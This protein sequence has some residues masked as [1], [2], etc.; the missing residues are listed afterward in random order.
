MDEICLPP[1]IKC[2]TLPVITGAAFVDSINPCAIAVLLILLETL[3]LTGGRNRALKVGLSFIFGL[4][5]AYLIFGIG[6]FSVLSF[7]S[8]APYLHKAIGG[9]AI[10]VGLLNIKDFFF[11]GKGFLME[12]PRSWR[13]TLGSILRKA[14]SP[15]GAFLIGFLVCLFELPCTGGPYIFALGI[16][17]KQTT[18]SLA[19][20]ILLYYNLIFVLP[21]LLITGLVYFGYSTVERATEWKEKNIKLL[22]LIAGI[23]MFGLGI[24]VFLS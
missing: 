12:I 13:P 16:L 14:I 19:L 6:L 5:L 23:I 4:Y 11:Y 21:L 10:L 2:F 22:H 17:A 7:R 1:E 8:L 24:W 9:L 20:L 15:V 3:I 18:K